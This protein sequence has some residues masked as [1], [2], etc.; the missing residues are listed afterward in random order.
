MKNLIPIVLF[1]L[2]IFLTLSL[3]SMK[4][5]SENRDEQSKEYLS[6]YCDGWSDGYAQG[7]CYNEDYGCIAPAAPLCPI[8]E[9]GRSTYKHG[10]NRGFKKGLRDN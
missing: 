6:S 9:V 5:L 1:G 2:G 4:P 7:Y 10:Y 8:P 3:G